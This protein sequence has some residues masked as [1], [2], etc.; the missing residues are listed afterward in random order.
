MRS[1][2]G[3]LPLPVGRCSAPVF[4]G[5][6]EQAAAG[7]LQVPLVSGQDP[8]AVVPGAKAHGV[9]PLQLEKETES[10][11]KNQTMTG[12]RTL[13]MNGLLAEEKIG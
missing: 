5:Q 3:S 6:T 13:Q 7:R 2:L 10:R 11:I 1:G 12:Y 8:H 9:Q 4:P